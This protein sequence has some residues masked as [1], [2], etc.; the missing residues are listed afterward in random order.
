MGSIAF[1]AGGMSFDVA[2]LEK[3]LALGGPTAG[4][5]AMKMAYMAPILTPFSSP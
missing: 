2:A 3:L 5:A 1:A 4:A